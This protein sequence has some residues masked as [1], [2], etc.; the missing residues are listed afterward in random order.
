[1]GCK[2]DKMD[3]HALSNISTNIFYQ[4]ENYNIHILYK[5]ENNGAKTEDGSNSF[6]FLYLSLPYCA[7]DFYPVHVYGTEF[8][9]S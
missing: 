5:G 6:D 9:Y 7:S 8:Y 1:M 3:R 4:M 2:T